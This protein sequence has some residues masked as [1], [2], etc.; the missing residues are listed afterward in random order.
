MAKRERVRLYD[1]PAEELVNAL[2]GAINYASKPRR[3][4]P[5]LRYD[6]ESAPTAQFS[7]TITAAGIEVKATYLCYRAVAVATFEQ[8]ANS[9]LGILRRTVDTAYYRLLTQLA[10][11]RSGSRDT[12]SR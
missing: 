4:R 9:R 3:S 11:L 12:L 1:G 8:L 5:R 2:K 6:L 10:H 7:F